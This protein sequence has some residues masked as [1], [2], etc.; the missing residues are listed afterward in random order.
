MGKSSTAQKIRRE[1]SGGLPGQSKNKK[2]VTKRAFAEGAAK[3]IAIANRPMQYYRIV[4]LC[5]KCVMFS[6]KW[7]FYCLKNA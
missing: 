2:Q 3:T 4:L 1:G 5:Q 6:T 7:S